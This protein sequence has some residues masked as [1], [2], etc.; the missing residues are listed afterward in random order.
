M[1]KKGQVQLQVEVA[2]DDDWAK[3]L[4]REGLIFVDVYTEWC[5]PC[6]AMAGNLKKIKLEVGGDNLHLAVAKC[7][8]ITDLARFSS[9]SEPTWMFISG[10]KLVNLVFGINSP[11]LQRLL[12]EELKN[13]QAVREGTLHREGVDITTLS[14]QEQAEIDLKNEK[15]KR[16]EEKENAAKIKARAERLQVITDAVAQIPQQRFG[17]FFIHP[18]AHDRMD[19]VKDT[20]WTVHKQANSEK[21]DLTTINLDDLLY[22]SDYRFPPEVLEQAATAKCTAYVVKNDDPDVDMDEELAQLVYGESKVPP[23]DPDSL[24][25]R[26]LT[27]YTPPELTADQ[28]MDQMQ[29]AA[30]AV[31]AET[32]PEE[33]QEEQPQQTEPAAPEEKEQVMMEGIWIPSNERTRHMA[34]YLFFPAMAS[35]HVPPEP[36]P[37]PPHI[38]V[39][40]DTWKQ[41]DILCAME[42]YP[43]EVMH[44][45]FFT[46]ED[47]D[48]ATLICKTPAAYARRRADHSNILDILGDKLVL[49]LS[50]KRKDV[51]ERF[52]ELGPTYMSPDFVT[53]AEECKKF[54]PDGYD[55]KDSDQ[56]EKKV[57]SKSSKKKKKTTLPAT[58]ETAVS[59][60]EE[61]E[62]DSAVAGEDEDLGDEDGGEEGDDV[63]EEDGGDDEEEGCRDVDKAT[64][65]ICPS[66]LC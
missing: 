12:L 41:N 46:D 2:N 20:I 18:Y 61:G 4:E 66:S 17:F 56:N 50:K 29:K 31:K 53:G 47:P 34:M 62:I 49:Q 36:E 7:N 51:V 45:G 24:G 11:S 39:V 54:F 52:V 65:P 1:A 9:K 58:D 30:S 63:D 42:D 25:D 19:L 40:Y 59:I 64:S 60:I 15:K 5:G 10:G 32:V 28:K 48:V 37:E 44:L 22:Y 16:K 57:K 21:I 35:A 38:A 8:N 13:E 43:N 6:S 3:L 14:P 27:P 26:L 33:Q 55:C 23:G